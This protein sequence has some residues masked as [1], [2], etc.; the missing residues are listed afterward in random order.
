VCGPVGVGKST[1]IERLLRD[2]KLLGQDQLAGVDPCSAPFGTTGDHIDSALQTERTLAQREQS[3]GS[4]V[5]HSY[6]AT[7]S[8]AFIVIDTSDDKQNAGSTA[9]GAARADHCVLVIDA[10]KGPLPET[11][12][13][14]HILLLLGFRDLLVVVN[15]MDTIGWDHSP[16]K[17]IMRDYLA[18]AV[19]LGFTNV[20]CVPA[21]ALRGDNVVRRSSAMPWYE[22]A[23]SNRTSGEFRGPLGRRAQ[24]VPHAGA[25]DRPA[26]FAMLRL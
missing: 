24:A 14:S 3:S 12:Y 8:R 23:H 10:C 18:F 26:G 9:R 4:N 20:I 16:F 13:Q 6:F 19:R 11:R 17:Q 1:L 25:V 21:S 22:V 2:C 15:K 5:G 7:P